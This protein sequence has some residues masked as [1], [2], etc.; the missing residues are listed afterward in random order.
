MLKVTLFRAALDYIKKQAIP[1]N[2]IIKQKAA[3][4]TVPAVWASYFKKNLFYHI[5]ESSPL[6]IIMDDA[7]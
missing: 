1:H 4:R 2:V 5:I 7:A 3:F 6:P